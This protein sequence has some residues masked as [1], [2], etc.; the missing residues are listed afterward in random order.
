MYFNL[1]SLWTKITLERVILI[2]VTAL[3]IFYAIAWNESKNK[4]LEL[5]KSN[6]GT[7]SE[8]VTYKDKYGR[9]VAK[10]TQL[11]SENLDAFI[12]LSTSD[13]LINELREVVKS[14]KSKLSSNKGAVILITAEGNVNKTTSSST[15]PIVTDDRINSSVMPTYVSWFSD[16]WV[17][18]DIKASTDSIEVDFTYVDKYSVILG[19]EKDKSLP[20]IK[21]LFSSKID[22]AWVTSYSPYSKVKSTKAVNFTKIPEPKLNL[23]FTVGYGVNPTN[24]SLSPYVGV[25]ISYSI[26]SLKL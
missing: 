6:T 2:A 18:Y 21:R 5:K 23:G 24:L 25:G 22:Y 7:S 26:L 14:N 1:K 12:K 11:E 13:S 9:E 10:S 16:E 17:E 3:T 15:L 4:Y 8:L 20:F 19:S